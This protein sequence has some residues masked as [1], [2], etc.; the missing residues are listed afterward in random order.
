[1]TT[2]ASRV[3]YIL[4]QVPGVKDHQVNQ[5]TH[6]AV[7]TFDDTKTDLSKVVKH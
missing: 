5:F 1:V 7:V 2:T 4:G 6:E 3:S